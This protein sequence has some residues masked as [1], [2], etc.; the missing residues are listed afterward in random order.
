MNKTSRGFTLVELM[1]GVVIV[2]ILLSIAIPSYRDHVRKTRRTDAKASMLQVST[3][4]ERCYTQFT[5]YN[6]ANC[7][8]QGG[9]FSSRDFGGNGDYDLRVVVAANNFTI[10]AS[11]AAGRYN[12][13]DAKCTSL[14]LTNLGVKTATGS[15]TTQCW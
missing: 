13:D 10:T 2:S 12:A 8:I 7:R 4:L 9:N 14:S 6:H 5:A 15:D 1:I 3:T 11:P